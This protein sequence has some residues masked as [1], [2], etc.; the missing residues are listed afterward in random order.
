MELR[1]L[2]Y[3]VAVAEQ[4]NISRAA[5]KIFLTQ[6][7]L[8]RQIKALEE[9]LGQPLPERQ[10]HSIRLTGA[11]EILL[12][13]ARDL[14][15]RADQLVERIRLTGSGPRLRVGYAPSLAAGMLATAVGSFTQLHPTAR[16][17]LFD[18]SSAEMLAG[19][20]RQAA[21][22]GVSGG[23]EGDGDPGRCRERGTLRVN[24][25][26]PVPRPIALPVVRFNVVL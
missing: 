15:S 9:D 24:R 19:S 5:Q 26:R 1:Q 22:G 11:G 8:S 3:F 16:V 4:G 2:R 7:A 12:H 18:L 14:L 13:E 10:A 21:V 25:L 23:I 6:P 20:S 17:E